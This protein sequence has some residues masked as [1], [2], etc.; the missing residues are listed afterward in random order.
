LENRHNLFPSGPFALSGP[1]QSIPDHLEHLALLFFR[2]VGRIDGRR[3][4]R[5]RR[6]ADAH[7]AADRLDARVDLDL[8]LLPVREDRQ[9]PIRVRVA[10]VQG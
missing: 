6:P 2:P 3:V 8:T 10:L 5:L 4:I 1:R 9:E 7:H